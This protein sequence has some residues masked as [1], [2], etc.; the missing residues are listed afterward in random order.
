M[1]DGNDFVPRHNSDSPQGEVQRGGA[2]GYGACVGCADVLSKFAL[3]GTH[4]RALRYPAGG[5]DAG[6]GPAF[7]FTHPGLRNGDEVLLTHPRN[8]GRSASFVLSHVRATAP[9]QRPA[10]HT[11]SSAWSDHH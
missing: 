1:A 11:N 7:R 8:C 5:D 6:R 3:E 9:A 2:T 4:L 10:P